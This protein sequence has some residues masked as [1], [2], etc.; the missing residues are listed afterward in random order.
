MNTHSNIIVVDEEGYNSAEDEEDLTSFVANG[1]RS[2]L[3]YTPVN[4][5]GYGTI[6]CFANNEI[7]RQKEACVFHVVPASKKSEIIRSLSN[8]IT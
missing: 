2:V 3:T 8:Y 1:T 6:L 5:R 4:Q 7:G